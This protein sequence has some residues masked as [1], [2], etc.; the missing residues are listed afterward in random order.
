MKA[1]SIGPLAGIDNA[2]ERDDALQVGG[3]DRRVYLRD[4]VNVLIENGRASMRKGL[5][6]VSTTPYAD[7]WQSPLHGDA[8]ARLGGQWVKVNTADWSHEV[9]AT[10]G[11][12][13]LGHLVLNGKVMV[14]APMGVFEYDGQAAKPLALDAPPEPM[15]SASAGAMVGG[16]YGMAVAWLRGQTEGP[17]SPMVTITVPQD[18]QI[19][20]ILPM[21]FDPSVTGVRLYS[22]RPDGGE[23]L[24]LG[25]YPRTGATVALPTLPALGAPPPFQHMEPMPSGRY[26]GQWNG[27][28]VV[29][30]GSKLRFSQAMAYHVHDPLHDFVQMPQR[31]TFVAP[32]DGGIWVGQ[33]DHVVFLRGAAPGELVLER[34]TGRAPVPG[35]VVALHSDEAGEA[36]GGGRAA[37]AWLSSVGFVLGTPDGGIIEP[38]S[39]RLRG[40]GAAAG[41]TVV[42]HGRL[43]AAIR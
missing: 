29:A 33:V 17:L 37:V 30:V 25:D 10:V 23:L 16:Q 5:R 40:I 2:S 14:A 26:L 8:F 4:A 31:I 11:N 21:A 24:R 35:S 43:V 38:Q 13:P 34:K 20:A 27:R 42:K 9:L 12:G 6:Q 7:L 1:I 41:S 28:L 19:D 36:A 3:Q 32:V 39:K 15:L 18:G 22:T